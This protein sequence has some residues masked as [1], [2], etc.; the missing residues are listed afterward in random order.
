MAKRSLIKGTLIMAGSG[1]LIKVI[2]FLFKIILARVI[3]TEGYGIYTIAYSIY[4]PLLMLFVSGI[5]VAI[6][7]LSAADNALKGQTNPQIFSTMLAFNSFFGLLL[8]G[9]FFSLV[10]PIAHSIIKDPQVIPALLGIT[11]AIF[12]G[13]MLAVFRGYFQGLQQMMPTAVSQMAEQM[14]RVSSSLLMIV[15]LLG[16]EPA[17]GALGVTLAA[18]LGGLAGLVILLG[19]YLTWYRQGKIPAFSGDWFQWKIV[20]K[21]MQLA[22]PITIGALAISLMQF[23][24]GTIIPQ[25][26]VAMGFFQDEARAIFGGFGMATSLTTFPTILATAISVNLIPAI[27]R[28][29]LKSP[30]LTNY[31]IAQAIRWGGIISFPAVV[32]LFLFAGPITRLIYGTGLVEAPLKVLSWS[33]ALIA[34]HTITT[35]IL[36]GLGKTYIPAKYLLIG[37]IVN[38][39]INYTLTP[40]LGIRGAAFGTLCGYLISLI[41]NFRELTKL[42]G[43][44]RIWQISLPAGLAAV[45]MGVVLLIVDYW[46]NSLALINQVALALAS[47]SVS[48]L[49]CL[50]LFKGISI[51]EIKGLIFHRKER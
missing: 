19:Y 18:G 26:L 11:P 37:G 6:S 47:G 30:Q 44:S 12:L 23:L 22:I 42:T 48:Y 17:R 45:G 34:L 38:G 4:S 40:V 35:G 32:G 1:L 43:F 5:P 15:F 28:S 39:L 33:V 8:A 13:A 41:G 49:I 27:A 29:S 50:I 24:D 14:V 20:K 2:G 10:R 3:G 21:I 25:R 36:Q 16:S 9:L 46:T 51:R 31:R 7:Q